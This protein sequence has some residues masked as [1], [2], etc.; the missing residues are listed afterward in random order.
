MIGAQALYR[1]RGLQLP[2]GASE[3]VEE[4]SNCHEAEPIRIRGALRRDYAGMS[5]D[6]TGGKPVRRKS[7]GSRGRLIRP[8]LVGPKARPGRR[9]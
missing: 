7:K 2:C 1:S 9:S 5:S 3:A 8:G 4:H 6:K